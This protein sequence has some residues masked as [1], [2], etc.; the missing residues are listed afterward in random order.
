MAP[1]NPK[2]FRLLSAF[3]GLFRGTLYQHRKSTLG[4]A[5]ASNLYEDLRTHGGSRKFNER[6][7]EGRCV[8]N[9]A[10]ST[11]GVRARRGDG[12]F[13]A[14]VPGSEAT[15]A[16]G[17]AVLQGMV[18]LTQI[19]A[20]FKI[21]ATAH[22]KQIDRVTN[23]LTGSASSLREKSNSAIT[24]GFAAVN[25]SERWTGIEGSRSFPVSRK[26]PRALQE[27][28]ETS[29]RL[30]H[31]AAPSYDEFLLLK[32]SATNQDPFP[33]SWVNPPGAAADYGAV[34]VRVAD[35][36]EKRF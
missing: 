5:V 32:F 7:S 3:E 31:L 14:T 12:T 22:L 29:R 26:P 20:E 6:V 19:G 11:R 24:V 4:N 1:Q 8:V 30:V 10:G 15:Q 18:A 9:V 17:F 35:L 34:L 28:E 23:D 21:I 27:S 2:V 36:Y 25:Y 13:G 16:E 33:F